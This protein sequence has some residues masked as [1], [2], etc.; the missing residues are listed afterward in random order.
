MP[1]SIYELPHVELTSG[2]T[3]VFDGNE[4]SYR[5]AMHI[6]T[7]TEKT[8]FNDRGWLVCDFKWSSIAL[9]KPIGSTTV[10]YIELRPKADP[11]RF[12]GNVMRI[13]ERIPTVHGAFTSVT[14][15][16]SVEGDTLIECCDKL[17]VALKGILICEKEQYI[18][19]IDSLIT[20]CNT[21]NQYGNDTDTV[22]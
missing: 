3:R 17:M 4:Y 13:S 18:N 11:Y 14:D 2:R 21:E 6:L 7:D 12:V 16:N 19:Y 15:I 8:Y 20:E 9:I 22:G 1:Y 5:S 10:D